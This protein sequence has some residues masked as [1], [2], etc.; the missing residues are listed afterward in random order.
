VACHASTVVASL[1]S[2][3]GFIVSCRRN[4]RN[5]FRWLQSLR[6]P[7][8]DLWGP[9]CACN[10]HPVVV[11]SPFQRFSRIDWPAQFFLSLSIVVG[12]FLSILAFD[13]VLFPFLFRLLLVRDFRWLYKVLLSEFDWTESTFIVLCML[14]YTSIDVVFSE[15]TTDTWGFLSL[16]H[17]SQTHLPGPLVSP[18]TP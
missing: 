9:D 13:A 4:R 3:A 18:T 11:G 7:E 6:V 16:E 14:A 2:F 1:A 8:L 12:Y 17:M 10:M 5:A 15:L